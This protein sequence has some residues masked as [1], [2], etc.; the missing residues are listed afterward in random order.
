[1]LR[2]RALLAAVV[3]S[4]FGPAAQA[5][6]S[7]A[8]VVFAGIRADVRSLGLAAIRNESPSVPP[9]VVRD[10]PTLSEPLPSSGE[11]FRYGYDAA[12]S[13]AEDSPQGIPARSAL[14]LK[15]A[16]VSIMDRT[17]WSWSGRLGPVRWLGPLDGESGELMLRVQ[18]IPGA[19]RPA[20]LGRLYVSIHY[21]FE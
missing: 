9:P 4:G 20:G 6:D 8:R 19:P 16:P 2:R 13:R 21:T 11:G 15:A 14:K 17:G 5:S 12:G 3:I 1:M 7:S 10:A 18:R